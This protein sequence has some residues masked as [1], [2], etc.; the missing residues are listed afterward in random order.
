MPLPDLLANVATL[1]KAG[2]PEAHEPPEDWAAPVEGAIGATGAAATRDLAADLA[3]LVATFAADRRLEAEVREVRLLVNQHYT[4]RLGDQAEGVFWAVP[5]GV[6]GNWRTAGLLGPQTAAVPLG[7]TVAEMAGA[8]RVSDL[9]SRHTSHAEMLRLASA[10][11]DS[12]SGT[13]KALA[14]EVLTQAVLNMAGRHGGAL[15]DSL[16]LA[17]RRDIASTLLAL[18]GKRHH[19]AAFLRLARDMAELL[20]GEDV[21]REWER[22]AVTVTRYAFNVAALERLIEKRSKFLAFDVHPDACKHCKLLYLNPDGTPRVIRPAALWG[23][24]AGDGGGLNIGRKASLIGRP[25]G[26][27]VALVMHPFV[28][29]AQGAAHE[30][31]SST[32]QNADGSMFR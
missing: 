14:R 15:S 13:A 27:Q 10:E 12:A 21:S 7:H 5:R 26:W 18:D 23:T 4:C 24:V 25:G 8:G 9:L 11:L 32:Q 16:A 20:D 6:R 28:G 31:K 17:R 2:E 30:K 22:A 29:A 19:R 3:R 1:L